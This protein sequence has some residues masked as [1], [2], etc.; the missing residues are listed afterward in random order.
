M[1]LITL[2]D[3][4]DSVVLNGEPKNDFIKFLPIIENIEED[5]VRSI[6]KSSSIGN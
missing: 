3:D 4:E 5:R 1:R 6:L 2:L